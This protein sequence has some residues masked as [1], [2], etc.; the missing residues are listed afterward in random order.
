SDRVKPVPFNLQDAVEDLD[1]KLKGM[2]AVYFLAGSRGKDLLQTDAFGA[3][4]SMQ[5]AEQV[6]VKRYIL[7]SSL[8]A[9]QPEK[10]NQPGL[11]QL[12]NYNIAKFFADNHLIN[13]TKLDYTIVQP[14][15]L[16]E[17]AGTGLVDFA[18]EKV[19]RNPIPDVAEVLEKLLQYPN[20]KNKVIQMLSGTEPID[21]GMAKL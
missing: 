15:G 3:V 6:G 4:K 13:Q 16:A 5:A 19:G 17:E 10:W 7:L 12:T 1:E 21:A 9:T 14:G 11:N 8:F 20:T 2:D 18:P